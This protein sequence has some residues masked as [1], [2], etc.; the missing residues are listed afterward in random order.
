MTAESAATHHIVAQYRN[1]FGEV[2]RLEPWFCVLEKGVGKRPF[3]PVHD[4]GKQRCV[5][6]KL[7]IMPLQGDFAVEQ[8][9]LDSSRVWQRYTLP[10][11]RAHQLDLH[12]LRGRYVQACRVPTGETFVNRAGETKRPTA[13]VFVTVYRDRATC[14]AAAEAVSR[15]M[16]THG[17]LT[18]L[19]P[20]RVPA[21]SSPQQGDFA[22]RAFAEQALPI[23]W[24]ASGADQQRF[25]ALITAHPVIAR[26]FGPDSPEV[27]HLIELAP[28]E[29]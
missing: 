29:L 23:L 11:L 22:E 10:S 3:D 27:T 1:Y 13:L 15:R 9:V 12:T 18:S 7:T 2:I 17:E 16:A 20:A 21:A 26:Y 6:I 19:Q 14:Q 25:L 4:Q 8:D 28:F 24:Q 5:A